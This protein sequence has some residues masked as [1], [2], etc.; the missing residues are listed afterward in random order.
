[1]AL[2]RDIADPHVGHAYAHSLMV[3]DMAK[4]QWPVDHFRALIDQI[5]RETGLTQGAL[6]ALVPMNQSQLSRWKEGLAKPKHESLVALGAALQE[7]YP[8]LN[9]GPEELVASVYPTT[10][11]PPLAE[12]ER[13]APGVQLAM[14]QVDLIRAMLREE[15]RA[16]EERYE[17]KLDQHDRRHQ[18]EQAALGE[19]I[20]IL[21]QQLGR[22]DKAS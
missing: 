21:R 5:L 19:Q 17:E 10:L 11:P 14:D 15:L 6:A 22:N 7:R 3:M 18:E 13:P 4:P 8:D 12:P 20:R 2:T 16:L 9:I 1:M